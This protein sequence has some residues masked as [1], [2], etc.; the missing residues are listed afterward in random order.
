MKF[1]LFSDNIGVISI[2]FLF[3]YAVLILI[4][5]V[6][7]SFAY[8]N[9]GNINSEEQNLEER[10]ILDSLSD[11]INSVSLNKV[12]YSRKISLKG[13]VQGYP[14]TVQVYNNHL[15]LYDKFNSLESIIIPVN[16]KTFTGT[17]AYSFRLDSGST[18]LLTNV[19]EGNSTYVRFRKLKS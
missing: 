12:G 1:R 14:Y 19:E 7:L 11:S 4:T 10:L 15:I 8:S 2:D 9:L 13:D 3:S 5:A 17:T 18:Y 6:L 16:I